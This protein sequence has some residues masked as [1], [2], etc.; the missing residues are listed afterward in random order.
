MDVNNN[1]RIKESF[2]LLWDV[3]FLS[4]Y[5]AGTQTRPF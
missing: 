1:I 5:S 4:K 3:F 2:I